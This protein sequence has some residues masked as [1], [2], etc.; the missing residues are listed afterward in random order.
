MLK[1]IRRKTIKISSRTDR[2]VRA[3]AWMCRWVYCGSDQSTTHLGEAGIVHVSR[4]S[5]KRSRC[6]LKQVGQ[7]VTF[8]TFSTKQLDETLGHSQ[9]R[10]AAVPST[11]PELLWFVFFF[12]FNTGGRGGV[13][14]GNINY[15]VR[16]TVQHGQIVVTRGLIFWL[17]FDSSKNMRPLVTTIW[18]CWTVSRTL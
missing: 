13:G 6:F 8:E 2:D 4:Y 5:V 18:P 14:G 1:L 7:P 3:T 16:E 12:F 17:V 10:L 11:S 9:N 15:S